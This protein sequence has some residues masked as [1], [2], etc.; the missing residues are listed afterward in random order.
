L[1]SANDAFCNDEL[2]IKEREHYRSDQIKLR[3]QQ[4][5]RWKEEDEKLE[6]KRKE[7]DEKQMQKRKD[8][9]VNFDTNLKKLD[10]KLD[11]D[12][13]LTSPSTL[14]L[15]T[16]SNCIDGIEDASQLPKKRGEMELACVGAVQR[17]GCPIK[18]S[19]VE[20]ITKFFWLSESSLLS[21]IQCEVILNCLYDGK[22]WTS[23]YFEDHI[24]IIPRRNL[25]HLFNRYNIY[26][27]ERSYSLYS[28]RT[29]I[30]LRPAS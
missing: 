5:Q 2:K 1:K 9:G 10:Q 11:K 30:G 24:N 12:R 17:M 25:H 6:L 7:E 19:S 22:Y 21:V 26:Y 3:E 8:E 13:A 18:N 15:Q 4:L 14:Q 16:L 29:L 23:K 28:L 20:T 27:G